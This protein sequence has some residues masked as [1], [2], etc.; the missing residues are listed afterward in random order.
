MAIDII[1]ASD[2][3]PY[4]GEENF[5]DI[6]TNKNNRV[7][8]IQDSTKDSF[9]NYCK[10]FEENGFTK[11]EYR[12]HGSFYFAAFEGDNTG[13]FVIYYGDLKELNIT[14]ENESKYFAYT[15]ILEYK[16]VSTTVTQ[17]RLE[18]YGMSYVIRL[19]DGRFIVFD[20]GRNFEPDVDS[21]Y[22]QLKD[23]SVNEKPVIACW[24]LTH[25]DSDHYHCFMGFCEKY[26]NDVS[27]QKM[28]FNFPEHDD[29]GLYHDLEKVGPWGADCENLP[30]MYSQIKNIGAE[31]YTPHTGQIYEIGNAS[32]EFLNCIGDVVH[33]TYWKNKNEP[34]LAIRMEIEGQTILWMGDTSCHYARLYEKFGA[35]LKA[36]ILQIPH[37]GFGCLGDDA[38]IAC[39]NEISPS[40]CFLPVS[41][42]NCYHK[43]SAYRPSTNHIITKLD[44]DEIITGDSGKTITLPYTAPKYA[45]KEYQ[46]K[47]ARGVMDNGAHSWYFTGLN[48]G[49][50]DDFTFTFLN[51]LG[52]SANVEINIYFKDCPDIER[53]KATVSPSLS[54]IC[55]ID[56]E[57]VD[58]DWLFYN[59]NSLNKTEIPENTDFAVRFISDIPIVIS[60]KN[61]NATYNTSYIK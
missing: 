61:H 35:Y 49:N 33:N 10:L 37:H 5:T 22:N 46:E 19:S 9:K 18:D 48:S 40:V 34:C 50:K 52:R 12:K 41:D 47:Y 15:D 42:Y 21:L 29:F 27:I 31:V 26:G 59:R 13:I 58:G 39:Y 7:F 23:T 60:H 11:R 51:T 36:D 32:L 25:P 45:K 53:I 54:D 38:E 30:K 14:V 55:I 43:I 1:N 16:N 6:Y 24:I 17:I 56:K 57:Q 44:V 2:F 28:M 4:F 8:A 3:I 20:G